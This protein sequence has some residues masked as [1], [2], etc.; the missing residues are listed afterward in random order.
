MTTLAARRC[1]G[2]RTLSRRHLD[3]VRSRI[4]VRAAGVNPVDAKLRRGDLAHIFTPQFPVIPGIE[5]SGVVSEVGQGVT[6]F[7]VGDA[8]FVA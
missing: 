6:A 8:V 3:R 7:D 4:E 1:S 2:L 5:V